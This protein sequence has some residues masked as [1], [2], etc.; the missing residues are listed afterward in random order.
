VGI[1]NDVR[2]TNVAIAG[3]LG[4]IVTF[5]LIVLLQVLYFRYQ[6]AQEQ[7]K[8]VDQPCVELASLVARQQELLNHYAWVDPQKKIAAIPIRRA[9]QLV[10]A[11][12]G[13]TASPPKTAPPAKT[14]IKEQGHG[15]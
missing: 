3:L 12:G 15:K 11:E 8:Q 10:L 4:A 13:K 2:T 5:A 6:T 7:T 9:M 1:P 14:A